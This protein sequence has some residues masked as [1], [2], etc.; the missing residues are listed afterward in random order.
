MYTEISNDTH[1]SVNTDDSHNT[2]DADDENPQP[3]KRRKPC[4]APAVTPAIC[5]GHTPELRLGGCGPLVALS[6]TSPE[7]EH[8]RPLLSAADSR[9]PSRDTSLSPSSTATDLMS[10]TTAAEYHE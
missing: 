2:C 5:P 8:G 4:A 7:I 9:L 10:V 1:H 3:A 6:A